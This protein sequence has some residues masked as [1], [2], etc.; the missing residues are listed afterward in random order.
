MR[1]YNGKSNVSGKIIQKYRKLRNMSREELAEKLQL[2][3][4]SY[5]RTT[6]YRIE[7][8]KSLIKD[9]ELLTICKILKIDYIEL[10]KQI[11]N[12]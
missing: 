6:V 3:G 9:F 10:E 8:G 7:N 2:L 4:I 1:K 11:D 5:D 12:K